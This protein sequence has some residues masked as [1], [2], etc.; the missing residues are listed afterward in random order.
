MSTD[1]IINVFVAA[2]KKIYET[3]LQFVQQF[4]CRWAILYVTR[5]EDIKR[6]RINCKNK[7]IWLGGKE[8]EHSEIIYNHLKSRKEWVRTSCSLYGFHCEREEWGGVVIQP[9]LACHEPHY[10]FYSLELQIILSLT[11]FFGYSHL[12]EASNVSLKRSHGNLSGET[13]RDN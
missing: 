13:R 5:S 11:Y 8:V 7:W 1:M 6:L 10:V 3:N 9:I 2:R 12:M 4:S